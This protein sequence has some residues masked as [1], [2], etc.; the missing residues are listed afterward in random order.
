MGGFANIGGRV[1]PPRQWW[2]FYVPAA[3]FAAIG[4][5]FVVC[6]ERYGSS[7]ASRAGVWGLFGFAGAWL[8]G[9]MRYTVLR[10]KEK[11][12]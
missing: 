10:R 8:V 7:D 3:L 6:N 4:C 11:V 1:P 12:H 9:G 5:A 2:A